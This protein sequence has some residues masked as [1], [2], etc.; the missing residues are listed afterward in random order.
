MLLKNRIYLP[1]FLSC[2]PMFTE[3]AVGDIYP[4]NFRVTEIELRDV[5]FDASGYYSYRY[6]S[7][8]SPK[9]GITIPECGYSG[10][11]GIGDI[12]YRAE[13]TPYRVADSSGFIKINDYLKMRATIYI[14][15]S[16]IAKTIPFD[17]ISNK[18]S[19]TCSSYVSGGL[20]TG[21]H[22][23]FEFI[24]TKPFISGIVLK[25]TIDFKLGGNFA[26]QSP[27]KINGANTL[28]EGIIKVNITKTK[29]TCLINDNQP[30]VFDFQTVS[31]KDVVAGTLSRHVNVDVDCTGG[32]FDEKNNT[33][34]LYYQIDSNDTHNLNMI[35]AKTLAG[36]YNNIG[37]KFKSNAKDIVLGAKNDFNY[38]TNVGKAVLDLNASLT[39][40]DPDLELIPGDFS[41][42][43]TMIVEFK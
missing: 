29:E 37:V 19:W 23:L 2:F 32:V 8:S 18:E 43:A 24:K 31:E 13:Y 11:L 36:S 6:G 21:K 34:A 15:R 22:V 30:I 5:D 7:S 10:I 17:N 3:A 1:L 35:K 33:Y 9:Y 41:A 12:L 42:T 26:G 16:E 39:M 40:V 4:N 14:G 20:N 25:D 27:I 38:N 28:F